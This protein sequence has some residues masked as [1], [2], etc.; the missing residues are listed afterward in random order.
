MIAST[1]NSEWGYH[2]NETIYSYSCPPCPTWANSW[3][4]QNWHKLGVVVWD[5]RTSRVTH[6]FGSQAVNILEMSRKSRSWKKKGLIVGEIAYR[7]TLP[8]NQ[9]SKKKAEEP[10]DM[11][12]PEEDGWCLTNTIQLPPD[13][14]KEFVSFLEMQEET[15]EKVVQ[16]EA[17]EKRRILG[18]VYSLILSWSKERKEGK[19]QAVTMEHQESKPDVPK[20][21]SIPDGKYLTI[22][23]V[24]KIC[25]VQE[26]TVSGWLRLG[27]LK[28]LELPGLGQIIEEKALEEYLA[29][30]RKHS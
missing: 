4:Q 18:K 25:A 20:A 8:S 30:K 16:A 17:A 3:E 14:A 29:K 19:A 12:P 23:Q 15:L 1:Q 7:I 10:T 6:M 5:A 27:F 21:I 11:K 28:G 13:Q 22:A 9:K 2:I 26:K 24:A